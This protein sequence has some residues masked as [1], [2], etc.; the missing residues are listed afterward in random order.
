MVSIAAGDVVAAFFGDGLENRGLAR[1]ILTDEEG[2]IVLEVDLEVVIQTRDRK[3]IARE[4]HRRMKPPELPHRNSS[5]ASEEGHMT[6][7]FNSSEFS[8][9]VQ[10]WFDESQLSRPE[11]VK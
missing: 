2:N 11:A 1:S 9:G 4:V 7:G 6:T 5:D 8:V 10:E 3:R